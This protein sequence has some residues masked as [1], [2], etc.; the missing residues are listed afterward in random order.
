MPKQY[1]TA[2]LLLIT[3]AL[4]FW[5]SYT[6]SFTGKWCY[7]RNDITIT[8]APGNQYKVEGIAIGPGDA[9]ATGDIEFTAAPVGNTLYDLSDI[10]SVVLVL[11]NGA[12]H[13]ADNHGCSGMNVRFNGIYRRCK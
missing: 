9:P 3:G 8:K 7:E 5:Y 11:N 12:L 1:T 4:W 6:P 2:L 13:V 10:C